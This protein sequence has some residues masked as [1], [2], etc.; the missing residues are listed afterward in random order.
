ME[1]TKSF[2]T[3]INETLDRRAIPQHV[4]SIA[5]NM[6]KIQELR[7]RF[8]FVQNDNKAT[9]RARLAKHNAQKK[10]QV[11]AQDSAQSTAQNNR[12]NNLAS[13][14]NRANVAGV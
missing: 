9:Y 4:F 1:Y 6:Q 14:I 5:R 11:T 10:T 13:L 3:V 12:I 2:K 7:E 8:G